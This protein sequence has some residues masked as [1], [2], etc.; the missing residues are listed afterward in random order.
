[1]NRAVDISSFKGVFDAASRELRRR[2][3]ERG[4]GSMPTE[5]GVGA[6]GFAG[7][8]ARLAGEILSGDDVLS[9]APQ[10]AEAAE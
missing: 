4:V 5:G 2:L 10:I 6:D 9:A 7:G 3:A 1:M 8:G